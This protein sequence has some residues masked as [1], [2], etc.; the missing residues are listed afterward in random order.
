MNNINTTMNLWVAATRNG[1]VLC[2]DNPNPNLDYH[3]TDFWSGY[4]RLIVNGTRR[5]EIMEHIKKW[6]E[7]CGNKKQFKCK[8]VKVAITVEAIKKGKIK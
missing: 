3:V 4:G 7:Q 5:W 8:A 6:N 2:Y 1:L